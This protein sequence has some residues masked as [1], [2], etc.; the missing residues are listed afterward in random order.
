MADYKE[1]IRRGLFEM[2]IITVSIFFAFTLDRWWDLRIDS[3]TE[4]EILSSLVGEFEQPRPN[5]RPPGLYMRRD[6]RLHRCWL[7]WTLVLLADWEPI[8]SGHC[9]RGHHAQ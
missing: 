1:R 6:M 2:M 7:L 9:G 8:R 5:S 4:Q 3:A